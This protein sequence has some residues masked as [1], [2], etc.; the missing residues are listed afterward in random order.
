MALLPVLGAPLLLLGAGGSSPTP[1]FDP[2]YSNIYPEDYV[3][4]QSCAECHTENHGLWKTHPHSRMNQNAAPETVL[5]DFSDVRIDYGGDGRSARFHA[6]GGVYFMSM[7]TGESLF[8]RFRI[9]RV[10]GSRFNQF[11]IGVQIEG[12]EPRDDSAYRDESKLP[13]AYWFG[14]KRWLPEIYFDSYPPAEMDYDDGRSY[15]DFI[16]ED[17]PDHEWET[18]CISCHN[19]YPYVN[20][21]RNDG[22]GWSKGFPDEHFHLDDRGGKARWLD[23]YHDSTAIPAEQLVTLGI[24][25]ETCHF[26]GRE[27][28]VEGKPISWI[29]RSPDLFLKSMSEQRMDQHNPY[30]VNSICAQCHSADVSRYE[31]N[32]P[33]WN[34][35]EAIDMAHGGCASVMKCTDCHNPHR[36]G[37]PGGAPD[38][39][40]FI[41][42]CLD[43]HESYREPEAR[44]AHTLHGPDVSCLDCHMPRTSQGLETVVR[45]HRISSPTD[46]AMFASGGPNAC[47]TCHIDKSIRWT[48]EALETGW[49]VQ[50]K[51]D[52]DWH[53]LYGDDL[54]VPVAEAWLTNDL[55]PM[56]LLGAHHV[57]HSAHG[58]RY[59]PELLELLLDDHAVNRVFGLM[60]VEKVAGVSLSEE[61]YGLLASP[62]VRRKQ[63]SQLHDR[64]LPG[65][66]AQSSV[67]PAVEAVAGIFAAKCS[68]C[69]GAHLETP[70]GD[71]LLDLEMLA[72]DVSL[73]EPGKPKESLL[74]RILERGEMPPADEGLEPLDAEELAAVREWIA[75]VGE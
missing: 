40:R 8:R 26:G 54:E 14:L 21:F 67:H 15:G 13:F 12:P 28:A 18:S 24:S 64:L 66:I 38:Q 11:Y 70:D 7:Y 53:D 30:V 34:S 33:M 9:T 29:P 57:S 17:A 20:R 62:D 69:H 16:F 42:A 27:H 46:P 19:T 71:F 63:V 47:S 52:S 1:E 55:Q 22:D 48:I 37:L 49:G 73:V 68:E 39:A 31:D 3:G 6:D 10:V 45:S 50:F 59:M 74:L 60:A 65:A 75:V 51:P 5:G 43:C 4:P 61:Q 56:R 41:N 72:R 44:A 58:S 32:S 2:A 23:W 36:P 25:C 35:A